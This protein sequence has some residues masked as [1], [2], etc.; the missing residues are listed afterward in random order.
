[1]SGKRLVAKKDVQILFLG[2]A[3]GQTAT[4][5][6]VSFVIEGQHRILV[7]TGPGVIRQLELGGLRPGQ[8]DLV[9]VSHCHADHSLG[10]PYFMFNFHIDRIGGRTSK[11]RIHVLAEPELLRRL[12]EMVETCYPPGKWSTFDIVHVP[13]ESGKELHL[14][15]GLSIQTIP[16][17]H[18]VPALGFVFSMDGKRIS[19]S[20]DTVYSPAFV[21]LAKGSDLMIH[22]AFCA[23]D[24]HDF[25]MKMKHATSAEAG[26]AANEAGA[27]GLAIVHVDPKNYVVVDKMLAE[28]RKEYSG[29]VFVP[30]EGTELTI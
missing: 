7:E 10:Y 20:S 30:T 6:T 16:V 17:E 13:A 26:R 2:S 4:R 27:K 14:F 21:D 19:Y 1:L 8:F 29:T 11:E 23:T 25:A 22:E 9:A 15:D 3:A 12:N 28:I 18:V 5:E 24:Q